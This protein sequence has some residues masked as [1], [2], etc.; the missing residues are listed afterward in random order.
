L[1]HCASQHYGWK[2]SF[3]HIPPEELLTSI[4]EKDRRVAE[5]MAE[6]KDL[7]HDKPL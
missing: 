3:E 2:D 6:I 7:L 5:L 4:L 1:G